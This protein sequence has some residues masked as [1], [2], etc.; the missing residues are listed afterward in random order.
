MHWIN[1]LRYEVSKR[2]STRFMYLSLL[3]FILWIGLL[4][5]FSHLW[6]SSLE[7]A[8]NQHYLKAYYIEQSGYLAYFIIGFQ[9]IVLSM[10]WL[11]EK[12]TYLEVMF[13]G[14]YLVFKLLQFWLETM[15]LVIFYGITIQIV[16]GLAFND[17]QWIVNLWIKL[18]LNACVLSGF[19]VLWIRV[20]STYSLLFGLVV[21][22]IY[23][24]MH[25]MFGPSV[26][27]DILLPYNQGVFSFQ[28]LWLTLGCY[29]VAFLFCQMKPK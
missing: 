29:W 5:Y 7:R 8:L 16:F 27:L 21:L 9:M 15:M 17:Y 12:K 20:K 10:D 2:K 22:V 19:M 26:W 3:F 14:Q 11:S 4:Y 1:F 24:N 18:I 13:R 6:T 25:S 28:P 23:P